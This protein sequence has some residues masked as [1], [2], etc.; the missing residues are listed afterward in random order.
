M[1]KLFCIL[2]FCTFVF[3]SS[4]CSKTCTCTT[5]VSDKAVHVYTDQFSGIKDC[6]ELNNLTYEMECYSGGDDD[7]YCVNVKSGVECK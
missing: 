5:Y 2:G 7:Y 3:L 4:S 1:K 6:S